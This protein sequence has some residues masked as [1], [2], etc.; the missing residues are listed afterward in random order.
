M[1]R[2][3][4]AL[5]AVLVLL[6]GVAAG[7]ASRTGSRRARPLAAPPPT[8]TPP[9][10]PPPSTAPRR[11]PAAPA[12][13]APS[14]ALATAL[15]AIWNET[16]GGCLTVRSG[17]KVLYEANPE[18]VVAPASVTKLLTAV[19]VLEALGQE[20]R[21]RTSVLSGAA[22]IDGVVAG[23][24]WLAGGGD[25]VLGTDA[26]AR[27][28]G[29]QTPLYT[30]LDALA[31]RV[32]AAGVRR[33]AGGVVGDDRR[34]DRD[35]Y[36]DTWPARLIADGEAGPL[37]ALTVNDGFRVWGHPGVPFADPPTGAAALFT[38]LLAARGVVVVRP[39]SSDAAGG[40]V[41]IAGIDSPSV[42]DLVHAMLR[43]SDNGTAE[44]LVKELGLRAF[45]D[46]S[47]VAGVRVLR[48][49]LRRA[50]AEEVNEI[51]ARRTDLA[52]AEASVTATLGPTRAAL[53]E[54]RRAASGVVD[55]GLRLRTAEAAVAKLAL[56]I[57]GTRAAHLQA[58]S[59]HEAATLACEEARRTAAAAEAGHGLHGGDPCPVCERK[60]PV[61]WTP[62]PAPHLDAARQAL[63]EAT[64]SLDA[65]KA[66]LM[67]HEGLVHA[68]ATSVA[69]ARED[70]ADARI[71][72]T[73]ACAALVD[74]LGVAP[75]LDRPDVDLLADL[76]CA[77]AVA[78]SALD[79]HDKLIANAIAAHS[80]L[81]NRRAAAEAAHHAKAAELKGAIER[82]GQ[83]ASIYSEHIGRLP[84]TLRPTGGN[85]GAE[86]AAAVAV[87]QHRR[88]VLDQRE[89]ERVGRRREIDA[90]VI[91]LQEFDQ[92]RRTQVDEPA[93]RLWNRVVAHRSALDRVAEQVE[94]SM[95]LPAIES[96]PM[97]EDLTTVIQLVSDATE[98]LAASA[99]A[100]ADT[101]RASSTAARLVL[102]RLA[103]DLQLDP[104]DLRHIVAAT[105]AL[106]EDVALDQRTARADAEAFHRRMP[107]IAMLRAAGEALHERYLA[108][109]DLSAALRDGAFPKWLTLRRSRSLLVHASRLLSEMTAGRYA[110]ADLDDE[111]SQWL[112]F[113]S[114]NGQPRSPA[115][116]S[117]GE[118][119]VASLA[120]AL[121]MVEMMG[122]QGDRIESLFLD[123]G[124]GALD[125]AN[126]DAAVEALAS[127]AATGRLVAVIT[128]LRAVAEQIDH[129]LSV[130]R[131]PTGTQTVWLSLSARSALVD[132]ALNGPGGLLE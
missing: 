114:D 125:R 12:V 98:Q 121:G 94:V 38:E 83:A 18:K 105:A 85:L 101:A 24:L 115:S 15:D 40:S 37:S 23:N 127:V 31:D 84:V 2:G 32:V 6:L 110:F 72:A 33:V 3:T 108:L 82:R 81:G 65:A 55:A 111:E 90:L 93:E 44:L 61:A 30:S 88:G 56:E 34:Y 11:V 20:T 1:S 109:S 87:L 80:S 130:T 106:A 67:R 89:T 29:D 112:V 50:G 97:I 126:L 117:G 9:S 5:T 35:R 116:L 132:D 42:G 79:A 103:V 59:S 131:E 52:D 41:A 64:Q 8:M 49:V 43:D 26:W 77:S 95:S 96:R 68:A 27:R 104:D 22:P 118:K 46:G 86:V 119:F 75:D 47:T 92:A 71:L 45:G 39:P 70:V 124:F 73:A 66:G 122:R 107:A 129:V 28:S 69:G 25:P 63:D 58:R 19:A 57:E 4:V 48:D 100:S 53:Q 78:T 123:E 74:Y 10:I 16:P 91:R 51:R 113:D 14:R 17:E 128:H 36:V 76:E 99:R 21:L 54:A 7:A 62:L 120:L 13:A 60:L 102:S